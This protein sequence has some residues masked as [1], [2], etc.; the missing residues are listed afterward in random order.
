MYNELVAAGLS[1]EAAKYVE[2]QIEAA[3]EAEAQAFKEQLRRAVEITEEQASLL[4]AQAV[5][6]AEKL[7]LA[8]SELAEAIRKSLLVD[9]A[10]TAQAFE[11]RF[12]V[13][14]PRNRAERR[15]KGKKRAAEAEKLKPWET[16]KKRFY[17]R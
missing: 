10:A 14:A 5:E 1:P 16:G 11:E 4:A 17:D 2:E 12:T 6:I 7:G 13:G 3:R 15:A 8:F 9:Q